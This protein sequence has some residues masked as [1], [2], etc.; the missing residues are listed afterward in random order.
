MYHLHL[1]TYLHTIY[2]TPSQERVLHC[3]TTTTI[4]SI[5]LPFNINSILYIIWHK[6]N[7]PN[8]QRFRLLNATNIVMQYIYVVTRRTPPTN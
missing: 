1:P 6:G 7:V 4:F 2:L 5:I 3:I 8:L